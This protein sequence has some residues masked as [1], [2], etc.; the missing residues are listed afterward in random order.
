MHIPSDIIY[1]ISDYNSD[2]GDSI[3]L[4][5]INREI[6]ENSHK[7]FLNNP[8]ITYENHRILSKYN[9]KNF[10]LEK[11]LMIMNY[12]K[13]YRK[14]NK[15]LIEKITDLDM[16]PKDI[17]ELRIKLEEDIKVIN[18]KEFDIDSIIIENININTEIIYP[19]NLTHITF[20]NFFNQLIDLPDSLTHLT[21]GY[22][23]NQP[24][25]LPN[26]L[27]HLTIG[28][29]FNQSITLPNNLT[30]LT[31]NERSFYNQ[32]INLPNSLTQLTFG[33]NYVHSLTLPNNLTHLTLGEYFDQPINL[34]DSLTHLTFGRT[35]DVSIILPNSLTHLTLGDNFNQPINLPDSLTHLTFDKHSN[36]DQPIT[37]SSN[38]MHITFG[39]CFNQVI[40]LPDSLVCLTF[41]G[42]FN[43]S[44]RLPNSLKSIILEDAL[45][46][47]PI[48]LIDEN[49]GK[50]FK[51]LE[52]VDLGIGYINELKIGRI[53]DKSKK[54]TIKFNYN[55][56]NR[57]FP[58]KTQYDF[59][60]YIL[61]NSLDDKRINLIW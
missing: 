58:N 33:R 27:T 38:L 54:V 47:W 51:D 53:E 30:Q 49:T 24:I 61:I 26:N 59:N 57:I 17:R 28:I 46:T 25:N 5:L 43:Q 12:N 23:Y 3:Y 7:I 6:Y 21:F 31:F 10:K 50:T 15:Y 36:F 37:L 22:E 19:N 14:V 55:F 32:P 20:G 4:S 18:L 45:Y 16:I 52:Y 13:Y 40:D 8:L 1:L 48:N 60:N 56:F 35:Y 42:R 11:N 44:I 41:G 9:L 39:K 34:P 29:C 2:V